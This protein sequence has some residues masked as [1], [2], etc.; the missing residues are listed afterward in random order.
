MY[1]AYT[2]FVRN[3]IT[4]QFYYGSRCRNIKLNKHPEED[5]WIYYFTS[6]K[7][8]NKLIKTYGKDSFEIGIIMKDVDYNK[9]Y[10]HEQTLIAANLDD[11]LCLNKYCR[12]TGQFSTA[13]MIHSEST[14]NKIS[15]A[16]TG[17]KTGKPSW[18]IGLSPSEETK[19]KLSNA[20]K[21]RIVSEETKS[22]M[23]ASMKGKNSGK[24]A[25][26][27]GK[28]H[29]EET[30]FKIREARKLQEPVTEETKRKMSMSTS[31]K[32]NHFYGK[33]HTEETKS[34]MREAWAKQK[35]EKLL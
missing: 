14:K 25:H 34:R 13:G 28:A 23:S 11:K 8:I 15:I 3:K 32:N 9:C 27:R 12:I 21:G 29:S 26:N 17:Q 20:G 2:Y 31:G 5:L 18:N 22:K 1:L 10:L 16:R 33:K 6:S 24:V 35:E 7:E 4:N 30:K 19:A